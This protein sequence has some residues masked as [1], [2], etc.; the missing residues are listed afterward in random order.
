[1]YGTIEITG[2]ITVSVN[3]YWIC[4]KKNNE[5]IWIREPKMDSWYDKEHQ[6]IIKGLN[7]IEKIICEH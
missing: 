4:I 6:E 5:I 7:H 2:G 1:M 3:G